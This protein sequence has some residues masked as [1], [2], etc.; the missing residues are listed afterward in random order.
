M[1]RWIL[2]PLYTLIVLLRIR[3]GKLL[4]STHSVLFLLFTNRYIAHAVLLVIAVTTIITQLQIKTAIASDAKH[5]LLYTLVTHGQDEVTEEAIGSEYLAKNVNYLGPTTL[6]AIPHI[7]FDYELE[8]DQI[9]ADLTVPGSIAVQP[10]SSVSEPTPPMVIAPDETAISSRTKTEMHIVQSGETVAFIAQKFGVNVGTIIWANNLRT[11][12]IIRPG[13]TLKIPAVSGVLYVIKKGDTVEKI[14]QLYHI[15]TDDIATANQFTS[16]RLLVVGHEL[17][18]PGATPLAPP[19]PK[20]IAKQPSP[21]RQDIPV[22]QIR[23]KSYDVYQEL[24][25]PSTDIRLKPPDEE[26]VAVQKNKLLWPTR[27]HLIN[28]YYGWRHT[29]VD[30]D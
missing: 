4:T 25:A 15:K 22:T 14:A 2:L 19:V 16:G 12:S 24:T 11:T 6:E 3:I 1:L 7:D 26:S 10:N 27:L 13:D 21:I 5:S 9:P 30:I 8:T 18:I 28:Q 20:K 23:N 29:G 17:I